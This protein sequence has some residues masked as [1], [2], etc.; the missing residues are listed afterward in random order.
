MQSKIYPET[1]TDQNNAIDMTKFPDDQKNQ[2]QVRL[3]RL[4]SDWSVLYIAI[5]FLGLFDQPC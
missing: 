4:N 2:A 3:N 5:R 1:F